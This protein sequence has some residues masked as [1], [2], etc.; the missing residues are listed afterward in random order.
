MCTKATSGDD[1]R[2]QSLDWPDLLVRSSMTASTLGLNLFPAQSIGKTWN[3]RS[4][5]ARDRVALPAHTSIATGLPSNC[6]VLQGSDV[7]RGDTRRGETSRGEMCSFELLEALT[8]DWSDNPE[9][10]LKPAE[11]WLD[12]GVNEL[13]EH[14][15]PSPCS[16]QWS[17]IECD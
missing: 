9:A 8:A 7:A 14:V 10:M 5:R 3:P 17:R 15:R 4:L 2:F 13:L 16:S 12:L 1:R 11:A 6:H